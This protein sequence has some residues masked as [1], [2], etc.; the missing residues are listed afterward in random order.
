MSLGF[1]NQ[2]DLNVQISKSNLFQLKSVTTFLLPV[3]QSIGEK[4]RKKKIMKKQIIL[5]FCKNYI[6]KNKITTNKKSL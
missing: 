1:L 6:I 4:R 2:Q 3:H 5:K